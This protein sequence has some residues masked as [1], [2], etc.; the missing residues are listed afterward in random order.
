M[1]TLSNS[2]GER[3]I[4]VELGRPDLR[5][6]V[7]SDPWHLDPERECVDKRGV[8]VVHIGRNGPE[9]GRRPLTAPPAT[10]GTLVDAWTSRQN[11]IAPARI[12]AL[13]NTTDYLGT[14]TTLKKVTSPYA[15]PAEV[16]GAFLVRNEDSRHAAMEAAAITARSTVTQA[17]DTLTFAP[18]FTAAWSVND[19][20][21]ILYGVSKDQRGIWLTN[22][23]KFW[24]LAGGVATLWLDLGSDTY[25]G[26]R[27]HGCAIAHHRYLF[28][29]P[30]YPPRVIDLGGSAGNGYGDLRDYPGLFPFGRQVSADQRREVADRGV[31]GLVQ[32]HDGTGTKANAALTAIEHARVWVRA[33]SDLTGTES[34]MV[35]VANMAAVGAVAYTPRYVTEPSHFRLSMVIDGAAD[36]S[37][38][39]DGVYHFRLRYGGFPS[40][41]MMAGDKLVITSPPAV[42]GTYAISG[43][44]ATPGSDGTLTTIRT[45]VSPAPPAGTYTGLTGYIRTR[46]D[47]N[48]RA[49]LTVFTN[50]EVFGFPFDP[51][52]THLEVWRTAGAGNAYLES[53]IELPQVADPD[54]PVFSDIYNRPTMLWRT[55]PGL[56][57]CQVLDQVLIAGQQMTMQDVL[58]GRLPPVCRQV[59]SLQG[60]SFFGGAASATVEPSIATTAEGFYVT[61]A[62]WANAPKLLTLA[63]NP[64]SNYALESGD[65]LVV[66]APA[67]VAG[68]VV[69]IAARNSATELDLTPWNPGAIGSN[70]VSGYIR[71]AAT[72]TWPLLT[73]DELLYC[74]RTDK[75]SPESVV[76]TP[77]RLST[78]GDTFQRMAVVGTY[79]AVIMRAGVHLVWVTPAGPERRTISLLGDGTP[80]PDSVLVI[81]NRVLWAT[82]QGIRVLETFEEPGDDG[83]RGRLVWLDPEDRLRSW[84]EAAYA[85]GDTIDAGLDAHNTCM[86]FRRRNGTLFEVLQINYK[87]GQTT[88]LDDDSGFTYAESRFAETPA[89]A[90]ELLYSVAAQGNAFEVNHYGLTHPYDG[91]TVQATL[92][93]TYTITTTSITKTGVFSAAMLGDIVRFRSDTTT[94]DGQ[95]RVIASASANAIGFAAVTGLASGDEFL[96]GAARYRVKSAPIL[97]ESIESVKTLDGLRVHAL[98]G[99]RAR[100]G[101]WPDP[102]DGRLSVRCYRDLHS[103][104]VD[105]QEREMPVYDADDVSHVDKD[106]VSSIGGQGSALQIEIECVETRTDFRVVAVT[107]QIRESGLIAD[108]SGSE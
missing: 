34:E 48:L 3:V 9:G 35:P 50:P 1:R 13:Y 28:V 90:A 98:P 97:G 76:S 15:W 44:L 72:L 16:V 107:P 65:V 24:L 89:S 60:V 6:D 88:L 53:R 47:G 7:T 14:T 79:L 54:S 95:V 105:Q 37:F 62:N 80:W 51:R 101:G 5:L 81:E 17:N 26:E 100:Q 4:Q 56:P 23:R 57:P 43:T 36:A 29:N 32:G 74:T 91:K 8:D 104:P 82:P 94:V 69:P 19:R 55:P 75:F 27:W 102:P 39:A 103:D 108:A 68:Q 40:W 85:A 11:G 83:R 30:K 22:G 99:P 59:A 2:G 93:N 64:W 86:R 70:N 10:E 52:W 67:A 33:V 18:A 92:D 106:R 38:G 58:S 20:F 41:E 96:I 21:S 25:L 49:Y 73:Q 84:F 78:Q 63:A 12:A 31:Y 87:T 61:G 71:R 77:I 42:A 45:N 66:T 46:S